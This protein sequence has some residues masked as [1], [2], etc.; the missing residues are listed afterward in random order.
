[1]IFYPIKKQVPGHHIQMDVKFLSFTDFEEKKG[2]MNRGPIAL[3]TTN[4]LQS[5]RA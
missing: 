2:R 3:Q 1:M 4:T 5:N